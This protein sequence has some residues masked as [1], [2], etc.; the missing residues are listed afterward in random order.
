MAAELRLPAE[1][2]FSDTLAVQVRVDLELLKPPAILPVVP[3][4]N[5]GTASECE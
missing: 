2:F 4:G 5:P 1:D 3:Q